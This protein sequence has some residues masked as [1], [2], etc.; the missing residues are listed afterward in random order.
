MS[1]YFTQ[2]LKNLSIT[3]NRAP[4]KNAL[5]KIRLQKLFLAFLCAMV[6]TLAPHPI[7]NVFSSLAALVT[8]SG[9]FAAW[10]VQGKP[11]IQRSAK[12]AL[13]IIF[14]SQAFGCAQIMIDG[15]PLDTVLIQPPL[16]AK[17]AIRWSVVI[18]GFDIQPISWERMAEDMNIEKTLLVFHGRSYGIIGVKKVIVIGV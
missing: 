3:L 4:K 10:W 2:K 7:I 1:D 17:S 13:V 12:L 16:V 5:Q 11:A 15:E 6:G 18:C 8:G 9:L 14:A